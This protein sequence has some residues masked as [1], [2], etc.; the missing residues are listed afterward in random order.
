MENF[1]NFQRSVQNFGNQSSG[2]NDYI[3]NFDSQ[4]YSNWRDR[5]QIGQQQLDSAQKVISGV[6]DAYV[7]SKLIGKTAS[8]I[9]ARLAGDDS[10]E[11]QAP[12]P[13][14]VSDNFTDTYTPLEE[15]TEGT[16]ETS[17]MSSIPQTVVSSSAPT[18]LQSGGELGDT[19]T[20]DAILATDP[21]EVAGLGANLAETTVNTANVGTE[22]ATALDTVLDGVST[23]LDIVGEATGVLAPVALL[24]GLG[25]SLY[26]ALDPHQ[27]PPAPNPVTANSRSELVVPS[28][29]SVTDTPASNSAF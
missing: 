18:T 16:E 21:E 12:E 5:L 24:A 23:G 15:A 22:S 13:E 3:S 7:A 27:R 17:F 20:Q 11:V 4:F 6:G 10:Q 29:D 25:V 2:L 1:N 26:E 28:F 8:Q 9:G 19:A 14:E